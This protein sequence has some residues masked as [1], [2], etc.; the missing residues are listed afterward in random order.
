MNTTLNY[1]AKV[2]LPRVT[3]RGNCS[4]SGSVL[5]Q[6]IQQMGNIKVE[7][8]DVTLYFKLPIDLKVR[9][10][11]KFMDFARMETQVE[12]GEAVAQL[13]DISL[14]KFLSTVTSSY[15]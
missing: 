3:L 7:I 4:V 2:I 6:S 1:T 11:V 8:N 5:G 9:D 13:N 14:S 12:A 15:A 10:G